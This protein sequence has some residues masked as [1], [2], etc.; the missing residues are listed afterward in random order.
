M[1]G[2]VAKF[3]RRYAEL[4]NDLLATSAQLIVCEGSYLGHV[5]PLV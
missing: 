3:F 2:F 1:C 5:I 4:C